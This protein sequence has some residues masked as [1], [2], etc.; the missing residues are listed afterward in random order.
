MK[1][2]I[3]LVGALVAI[4][5][6]SMFVACA[7]KNAPTPTSVDGCSCSITYEDGDKET[8]SFSKSEMEDDYDV[9]SCE[10]LAKTL[11]EYDEISRVTCTGYS[12]NEDED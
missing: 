5:M 2:Q 4:A 11:K 10:K 9:K 8:V 6:S 12:L 7:D 1:K 3:F